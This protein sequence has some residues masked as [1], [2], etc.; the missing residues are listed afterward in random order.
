MGS[1]L[2]PNKAALGVCRIYP[3]RVIDHSPGASAL[4]G[5]GPRE[6]LKAPPTSRGE[7]QFGE[8]NPRTDSRVA[9]EE[10]GAVLPVRQRALAHDFVRPSATTFGIS[11]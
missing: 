3:A 10:W 8:G 9:P 7:V 2:G 1:V 4:G 11:E 6:A 5:C